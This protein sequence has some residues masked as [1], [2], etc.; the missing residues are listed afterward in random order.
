MTT[1]PAAATP[2]TDPASRP[3]LTPDLLASIRAHPAV[4][5]DSCCVINDPNDIYLA[6]FR[7]RL[8]PW[9]WELLDHFITHKRVIILKA[10]QLGVSWLLAAYALWMFLFYPG[11]N[12]LFISKREEDAK[13]L[14]AKAVFMLSRLPPDLI[15]PKHAKDSDSGLV[16]HSGFLNSTMTALAAVKGA[17]RGETATLVIPDEWAFQEYAAEMYG[18]YEP[19]VGMAGEIKGCST[20]NGPSGFF[21]SLYQAAKLGKNS[22]LPIFLGWQLRPGRTEE[23]R[24][25]K[26]DELKS[27]GTPELIASEYP[28]DDLDAFISSRNNFFP[29]DLQRK[30]LAGLRDPLSVRWSN[31]GADEGWR[32]YQRPLSF[33]RYALGA[34]VAMGIEGGNYSFLSVID[35]AT[36]LL[37]ATARLHI[38]PDLWAGRVAEAGHFYND[39]LVAVERNNHGIA[40]L[41]VLELQ[42]RYPN[43]YRPPQRVLARKPGLRVALK[44]P[45]FETNERTK[46]DMLFALLRALEEGALISYDLWLAQEAQYFEA[47]RVNVATVKY[48]AISGYTD[49]AIMATAIA[50]AALSSLS[51]TRRGSRS[52]GALSR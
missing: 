20:A 3:S 37:C 36:G 5:V 27:L 33:H 7:F 12:I 31:G 11:S 19:T 40:T 22:F 39:A 32:L 18:G 1:A 48:H 45:G 46:P 51:L 35:K 17:G 2:D 6:P 50:W 4:F 26:A 38:S 28:S 29:L 21:Y 16:Y 30:L 13:K 41:N 52:M 47:E 44:P 10:R 34:D 25:A 15:P 49:D 9:Q 23:W 43:L 42:L 14:L 8:W 24:E